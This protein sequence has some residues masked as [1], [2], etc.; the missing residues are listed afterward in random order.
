MITWSGARHTW[1]SRCC[2]LI[3]QRSPVNI[4]L[5]EY[6][7]PDFGVRT[8]QKV[9]SLRLEH[10]ILVRNVDKLEIILTLLVC[11][12]GKVRVPLLAVLSNN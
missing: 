3:N 5:I 7:V 10:G 11:D 9:A 8:V 6:E 12:V 1:N 4:V 2:D